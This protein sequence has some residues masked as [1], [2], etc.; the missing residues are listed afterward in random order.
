MTHPGPPLPW[1]RAARASHSLCDEQR[2]STTRLDTV[3]QRSRVVLVG[4][5]CS[6]LLS[7]CTGKEPAQTTAPPA[8]QSAPSAPTAA[9]G[10]PTR[11]YFGDTHL[12]T[13]LSLDAGASGTQLERASVAETRSTERLALSGTEFAQRPHGRR[14]G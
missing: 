1:L 3:V 5:A 13:A 12:H 6:L 10:Y 2:G 11:V 9:T 7:A 8:A 14:S 4:L